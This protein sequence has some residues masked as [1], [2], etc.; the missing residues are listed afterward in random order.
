MGRLS[1]FLLSGTPSI[2]RNEHKLSPMI[3]LRLRQYC[4]MLSDAWLREL[5]PSPGLGPF[6]YRAALRS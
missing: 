4:R 6:A 2:S 1:I 5:S 3:N